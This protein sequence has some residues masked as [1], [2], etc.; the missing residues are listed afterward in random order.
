MFENKIDTCLGKLYV[1]LMP[2]SSHNS[3]NNAKK[4]NYSKNITLRNCL[5]SDKIKSLKNQLT[6]YS[7]L[8]TNVQ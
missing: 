6:K 5:R 1:E 2:S 8:I 7:A 4:Y 3:I